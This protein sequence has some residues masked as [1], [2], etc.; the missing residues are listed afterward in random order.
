MK[1]HRPARYTVAILLAAALL[2]GCA[3]NPETLV[4]SAKSYL[5][6]NEPKAAVIQLRNALQQEPDYAEARYLL[7][8]TLLGQRDWVTAEKEL[9]R[10][11]ELGF[12]EE[13][14]LPP[15][16]RAMVRLGKGRDLVNEYGTRQLRDPAAQA[17]FK[18]AIGD[19]WLQQANLDE[20]DRAYAEALQAQPGYGAAVAGQARVLMARGDVEAAEQRI[21]ATLEREPDNVDVLMLKAELLAAQDRHAEAEQLYARVVALEPDNQEARRAQIAVLISDKRYPRAAELIEAAQKEGGHDPQLEYL[22]G[23][24]ALREGRYRDAI[25]HAEQVLRVAPEHVPSLLVAG[26]AHLQLGAYVRAEEALRKVVDRLPRHQGA[27][28]MLV[29][30]QLRMGQ[31]DRALDTLEP[32]LYQAKDNPKVLALA[33]EAYLANNDIKRAGEYFERAARLDKN[34][35]AVRA[36]LGQV[37][38]ARGEEEEAIEALEEASAAD[39]SDYRAD[40]LLVLNYIRAQNYDKAAEALQTLE[41]KQPQNP[42]THNLKG[43][44]YVAQKK[45]EA[46]RASFE[47]A[48][49]FDP[50]YYPAL[51]NLARL[52][53][54]DRKP[55][56]A[57][58]RFEAPLAKKPGDEKLL[59]GYASILSATG[60]DRA[61]VLRVI[62]RAVEHNPASATAHV[63]LINYYRRTEDRQGAIAAA[64]N[65]LAKVP[66]STAVLDAAGQAL[67]A[68]GETQQ[69]ISTFQKLVN[70]APGSPAGYLRLAQAYGVEK[71]A[72]AALQA[73]RKAVA[74][75]P[76]LEQA[77]NQIVGILLATN[78][79][80]EALA[81][82]RKLQKS[83]PDNGLGWA[84]EGDVHNTQQKW[85]DAERGY[86]EALKRTPSSTAVFIKLH[87]VL[88]QSGQTAAGRTLADQWIKSHPNDL[89]ARNYLAEREL[90]SR[91]YAAA[92]A[93]YKVILSAEPHNA[94][95]LNNMAW[96]AAQ[97]NDP[98]AVEY[99]QKAYDIAPTNPAIMDTLGTL[100]VDRGDVARGLP[101]L[102]QAV[103]LAP[104]AAAI[105][106]NYAK[107]LIKAGKGQAAKAELQNLV[108]HEN[109]QVKSEA[110]S[111]LKTL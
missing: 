41:Q 35:P 101:L 61:E 66:N 39:Q 36:R 43:V 13:Q 51:L 78:R 94:I 74:L 22:K 33:G 91:D 8:I 59:L 27:R 49:G 80:E 65:A 92:I 2:A 40:L 12:S 46:G 84:L 68:G 48:L 54:R 25:E 5:A 99:A 62:E 23:L 79:A 55:A 14:V 110:E 89:V 75:R 109:A 106:M 18:T 60:A 37:H 105:R 76:D 57:R 70:A 88:D 34:D 58:K 19:A 29:N 50:Y 56:E 98:K 24:L 45:P 87:R 47:K 3:E 103:K 86:R 52:D 81:E 32:L 104:D 28:Q 63:A 72:D 73:L 16:A 97:Q 82:A 10:A 9:R 100:L 44:L 77:H 93:H 83:Q 102:E 17:R 6:K 53:I 30:A 95:A 107:A 90:R 15:L 85:A 21:Q 38:F 4:N 31:A 64:H 42:L 108:N 67:L 71:N 20:A 111:L 69:A 11:H 96:A 7:G 26:S 1:N